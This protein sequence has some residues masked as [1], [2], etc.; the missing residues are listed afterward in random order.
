MREL[1]HAS[2][3][4]MRVTS[5]WRGGHVEKPEWNGSMS[6]SRQATRAVVSVR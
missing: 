2:G 1:R 3:L 4:G 5:C 6:V